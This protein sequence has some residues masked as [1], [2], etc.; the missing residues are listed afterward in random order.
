MI[1]LY[2]FGPYFGLPDGS[3]FVVKA[4]MLLKLSGLPYREDR[5][6]LS[7]AA[8]GKLPREALEAEPNL[9]ACRDRMMRAYF[10][11]HAKQA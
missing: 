1:T 4:M 9:V 10:P 8:K 11:D 6:G 2:A 7:K 5:N 3:P